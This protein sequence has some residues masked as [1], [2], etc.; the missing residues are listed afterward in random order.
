MC[1]SGAPA[2]PSPLL[3]QPSYP[4]HQHWK[5]L[6]LLLAKCV[7]S[8]SWGRG[9]RAHTW[10]L[11]LRA[12]VPAPPWLIFV[13]WQLLRW[14]IKYRVYGRR[15]LWSASPCQK[16]QVSVSSFLQPSC[17]LFS[18]IPDSPKKRSI[19]IIVYH[20]KLTSGLHSLILKLVILFFP[21]SACT[22]D[23]TWQAP[24]CS[25]Y[26]P[27]IRTGLRK[28]WE[29]GKEENEWTCTGS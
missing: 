14:R 5:A 13:Y 7:C 6:Y 4:L 3:T 9:Y 27:L 16:W 22:L 12:P 1:L 2:P 24:Y 20:E 8:P 15:G 10:A 29:E 17:S 18:W 28:K 11:L 19:E 23:K 25:G 21:L 26:N